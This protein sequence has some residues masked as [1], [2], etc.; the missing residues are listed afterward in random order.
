[1]VVGT[2][3]HV[4]SVL[5]SNIGLETWNRL[6][7]FTHS[8]QVNDWENTLKSAV[9]TSFSSLTDSSFIIVI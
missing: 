2:L 6:C 1:M 3:I 7:G 9:I 5:S 8:I 4:L